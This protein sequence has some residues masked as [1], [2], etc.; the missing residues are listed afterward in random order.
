MFCMFMSLILSS[1]SPEFLTCEGLIV[2][3]DGGGNILAM[4]QAFCGWHY[5]CWSKDINIQN[6]NMNNI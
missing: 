3:S 6:K 5:R 2:P 1:K 4:L